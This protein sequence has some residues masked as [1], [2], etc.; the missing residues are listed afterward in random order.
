MNVVRDTTGTNEF[1]VLIS[2]DATNV[3]IQP[4]FP[5]G[6]IIGSLFAVLQTKWIGQW[7]NFPDMVAPG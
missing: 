3:T 5:D 2:H 1:G 7:R 4:V 6:S